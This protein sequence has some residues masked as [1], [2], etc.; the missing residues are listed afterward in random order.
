MEG[1]LKQA[2][3]DLE[4]QSR[5]LQAEITWDSLPEVAGDKQM[6]TRL[7]QNLISNALKYSAKER[8]PRIHVA[9][10]LEQGDWIFSVQ[11]NG[12]G[13]SSDHFDQVFAPFKRLHG[14]SK[15]EGSGIGLT[16]C[17]KIIQI[18]RGKIWLESQVGSG[19]VFMFSL[20]ANAMGAD[21]RQKES[22]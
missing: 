13:I 17:R 3:E 21:S 16:I 22:L 5:E 11:D 9:A 6:L 10:R 7:F 18:H 12:I 19:S 14:R 20:T 2:L 4:L 1:C 15:Y 8:P